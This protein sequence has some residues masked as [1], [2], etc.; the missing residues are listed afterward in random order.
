M[1]KVPGQNLVK[2]AFLGFWKTRLF[3]YG[4]SSRN[5][6][7]DPRLRRTK[8][9]FFGNFKLLK[10]FKYRGVFIGE[11]ASSEGLTKSD[12]EVGKGK[13][14]GKQLVNFCIPK[15]DHYWLNRGPF[16]A[17]LYHQLKQKT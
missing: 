6:T 12:Q 5:R 4:D 16:E 8:Y 1:S 9:P 17:A 10:D 15:S 7:C 3:R 14:P 2:S 13:P 11:M